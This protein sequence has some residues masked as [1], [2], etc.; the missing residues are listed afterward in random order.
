MLTIG[1]LQLPQLVK[2]QVGFR[3]KA[4]SITMKDAVLQEQRTVLSDMNTGSKF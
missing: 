3:D 1:M 2:D 4:K